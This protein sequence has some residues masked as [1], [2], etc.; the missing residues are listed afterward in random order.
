[1]SR[2]F[3]SNIIPLKG[4]AAINLFGI[5]IFRKD[6]YRNFLSTHGDRLAVIL[7]HEEI[8]TAQMKETLFLLFYIWYGIEY[9]F[10]LCW[11]RDFFIA[12][13]T[14]SFEREAYANEFTV[15]YL[16]GRKKYSWLK[17]IIVKD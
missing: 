16:H 9:L 5:I 12:F 7:S 15:N 17:Y 10:K 6:Y 2:Y 4:Y 11:Y 3:L 1:M 13:R 8:H 14:I